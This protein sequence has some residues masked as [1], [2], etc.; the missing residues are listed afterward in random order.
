M[1]IYAGMT[2]YEWRKEAE[3]CVGKPPSGTTAQVEKVYHLEVPK[4]LSPASP[5]PGE[6]YP[7]SVSL[8][9]IAPMWI[10]TACQNIHQETQS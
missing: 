3:E 5:N 4:S 10:Y 6:M 9:S 1:R 2:Q 8:S 7:F